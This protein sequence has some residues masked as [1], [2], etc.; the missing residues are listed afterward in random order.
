MRL[1]LP[2]IFIVVPLAE[3]A[4]LIK[5]GEVIGV[6]PT[7]GLVVGTAVVGV[8]LIKRQG[9]ATLMRARET[10]DAGGLP[11]EP[12]VEG[13]C[14]LIAGAFLLTP[15]LITD[16]A[17]FLL[18]VPPFRRALAHWALSWLKGSEHVY[19]PNGGTGRDGPPIIE[20][21]YK[22]VETPPKKEKDKGSRPRGRSG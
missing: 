3:I 2:L 9:L 13:I 15:G 10:L 21:E 8:A 18:L 5:I 12:A 11:L 14:L 20:G 17:G 7:I 19:R 22:R 4:L 16:T 1:I 6:L